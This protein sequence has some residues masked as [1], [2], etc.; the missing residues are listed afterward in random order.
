MGGVAA[1]L[2]AA[3]VGVEDVVMPDYSE[4][5]GAIQCISLAVIVGGGGQQWA[6]LRKVCWR[7]TRCK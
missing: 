1:A 3:G 4:I 2:E 5:G 6:R 7:M